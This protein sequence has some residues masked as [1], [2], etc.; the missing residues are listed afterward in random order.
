MTCCQ[1]LCLCHTVGAWSSEPCLLIALQDLGTQIRD[2]TGLQPAEWFSQPWFTAALH[3]PWNKQGTAK[4]V[5]TQH[6]EG[7]MGL[8]GYT[9]SYT[10]LLRNDEAHTELDLFT[11]QLL[12]LP[13]DQAGA[14][15]IETCPLGHGPQ[16][17]ACLDAAIARARNVE[18]KPP[19]LKGPVSSN[20][21]YQSQRHRSDAAQHVR[22]LR[23]MLAAAPAG[24]KVH[25]QAHLRKQHLPLGRPRWLSAMPRQP[26]SVQQACRL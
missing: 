14:N 4:Y 16:L 18:L 12:Q 6:K 1:Q 7:K 22:A 17:M 13:G 25:L 24:L 26:S 23:R 11:D 21:I 10:K 8:E 15:A 20:F 2:T 5:K 19:S 9:L 3:S